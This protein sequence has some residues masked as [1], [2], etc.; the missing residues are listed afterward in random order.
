MVVYEWSVLGL[1]GK[2]TRLLSPFAKRA[3]AQGIDGFEQLPC[4]P[5]CN[6]QLLQV[7]EARIPRQGS[8]FPGKH[9]VRSRFEVA[10]RTAKGANGPLWLA[11]M[12]PRRWVP[13]SS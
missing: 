12:C 9:H 6:Q 13:P 5:R 4:R 11:G 7:E 8:S 2:A 10:S 3:A 1:Q